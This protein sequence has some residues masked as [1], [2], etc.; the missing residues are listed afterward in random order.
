MCGIC[1]KI[2]LHYSNKVERKLIEKM[3]MS[4]FHRGPDEG[5]IFVHE[6]VGLGHRRL[7]IID[8]NTGKQPI[9]NEDN[10]LLII[11][12]GE[13]YNY[14]ELRSQLI[15]AGHIFKTKSD[16]EVILHL[17]EE[18]G[19][20]CLSRLRGMFAFAI[21]DMRNK[22]LFLA[23][24]RIGIKPL[25]YAYTKDGLIFA[26]EFKALMLDPGFDKT[27]SNLGIS[28]FLSFTYTPGPETI[29]KNVKKLQPGHY[30][31]VQNGKVEIQQY[32]DIKTA[33]SSFGNEGSD[34]EAYLENLLT[35]TVKI[36]MISDVPVGFL[37][38]GGIDSTTTLSFYIDKN[39]SEVKTFTIGFENNEFEDERIYARQAAKKFGVQHYE[40]TINEG[41]FF[42][43][44]P[45]FVWHMEEPIFEP[46]AVSL[47]Y[48]SK[49]AREQVKVLISGE[50]GDEAFAGYQ[51][52]RNIL[53]VEKLKKL[54]GSTSKNIAQILAPISNDK[55]KK[56]INLISMPLNQYYYS[57][58]ANPTSTFIDKFSD[59]Y[60]CD[61]IA[62]LNK[63][64]LIQPFHEYFRHIDA[65]SYLRQMLYI[66]SKTWLPDR[67]LIKADKMTMANSLELRV[68]LL[69]HK[70]LEYAAAL[71]DRQKVRG[72]ATK[73]ILKK[74]A[75][76]RIPKEII[77]RKKAGFPT[78][79][80]KWLRR[81]KDTVLNI[82]L[83][84]R[85]ISRD[86]FN[87]SYLQ[88]N[89]IN[90]WSV[91]GIYSQEIFSLLTLELWHRIFIDGDN[92]SISIT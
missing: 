65:T 67:L 50:G 20:D 14:Q 82:L 43:F 55:L 76:H 69:D 34:I 42:D 44:L 40:T 72:T 62:A 85:T 26:S 10:Q 12:N 9:F 2:N 15:G 18:Y 75:G 70:V 32:W 7:S 63:G 49:M 31:M 57:R 37:L 84:P 41:N 79:Y 71:P 52:Y 74:V 77:K 45:K 3:N 47:Y 16:T 38:S 28:Q 5:S 33:Y 87:Y 88:K 53:I 48:V 56:Y 25:Y 23:R 46:P 19:V 36:H 68:P 73:Y 1:G 80:G 30:L 17:Y 60:S 61:F 6:N 54:F 78:P 35:E 22:K 51:T 83:D 58:T 4:I 92:Q 39:L 64:I 91:S 11:F 89:I 29:F 66:D 13:I 21:Y 81:K 90:P 86:Y 8:L 24:D 27:I 59:I